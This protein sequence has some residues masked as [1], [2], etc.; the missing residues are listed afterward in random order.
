MSKTYCELNYHAVWSTYK[1]QPTITAKVEE[2]L[3]R[4]LENK[5]KRF[6][7]FVHAV[8]GIEDHIHLVLRIPA[9]MAV[10]DFLG[11]LKGASSYFLN[12]ELQITN[13]FRWQEGYGVS[14]VSFQDLRR[15]IRYVQNQ[16]QRHRERDWL[17]DLE[18]T[19]GEDDSQEDSVRERHDEGI[20]NKRSSSDQAP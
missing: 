1:R 7:G 5:A 12:Q 6:N 8:G 11:K 14:S 13:S 10:G 20:N 4:F 9:S 2:V 19:E 17:P 3:Y 16:K 15:V 18:R